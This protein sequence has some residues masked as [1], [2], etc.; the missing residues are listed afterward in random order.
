[1]LH[2]LQAS[3]HLFGMMFLLLKLCDSFREN[4]KYL[5]FQRDLFIDPLVT[6]AG[7]EMKNKNHY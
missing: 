2:Q 6:E 1:M 4:S 5:Q 3:K 7:E